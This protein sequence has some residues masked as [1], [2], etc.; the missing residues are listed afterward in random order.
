M[1]RCNGTLATEPSRLAPIVSDGANRLGAESSGAT[2][3]TFHANA[4][5]RQIEC[6]LLWLFGAHSTARIA[7]QAV[8]V[9]L[10]S[11]IDQL[12]LVGDIVVHAGT[13]LRLEAETAITLIVGSRQLRVQQRGHLELV[14]LTIADSVGGTALLSEGEVKVSN[15]SFLRCETGSNAI[16]R[17]GETLVPVGSDVNPPVRGALITAGGGAIKIIWSEATLAVIGS[18]FSNN[19]AR[20]KVVSR[21]GAL[22]A[23]GGKVSLEATTAQE[24]RVEMATYASR[25]GVAS[26]TYAIFSIV[27]CRFVQ[28]TARHGVL[29]AGGAI[30][31]ANSRGQI[32]LS[33]FEGNVATDAVGTS[34][35]G[36]IAVA[37]QSMVELSSCRFV[38]NQALN[39][40]GGMGTYGGAVSV[41]RDANLTI[42][43]TVFEGNVACGLESAGGAIQVYASSLAL[44]AGVCFRSN[45]VSSVTNAQG[46]AIS[47]QGGP[48]VLVADQATRF[49]GNTVRT[50]DVPDCH[51]AFNGMDGV[52]AMGTNPR[53]GD[54]YT[55]HHARSHVLV[56]TALPDPCYAAYVHRCGVLRRL[57]CIDH[58]SNLRKQRSPRKL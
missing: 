21:G 52:Q 19:A 4:S 57:Q 48:A 32:D 22:Y 23:L 58:R 26:F 8:T 31:I 1:E 5:A 29:G 45:N 35:G 40:G 28:N 16:F 34:K 18:T 47:L 14:G 33:V 39:G 15:C 50:S 54:L 42:A 11:H 44:K 36:G 30:E 13:L 7:A 38:R 24:N 27:H 49:I 51:C 46:G 10:P 55:L 37:S 2:R 9:R 56:V 53:G 17:I 41:D 12:E 43:V 25:G 3:V 20:G 6:T